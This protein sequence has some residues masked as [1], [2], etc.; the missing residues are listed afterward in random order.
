MNKTDIL[1]D[2][3]VD[4]SQL[5]K[6]HLKE[7][8][9]LDATDQKAFG[10]IFGMMK[11]AID[12]LSETNESVNESASVEA[13]SISKYT[14][15]RKD[16]VQTF[17]DTNN[18]NAKGLLSYVA[19]GKMKERMEFVSALAGNDGNK[20]QKNIIK[21]FSES[22]NEAKSKIA[23]L[24]NKLVGDRIQKSGLLPLLGDNNASL[25]KNKMNF[26]KDLNK[27]LLSLFKKYGTLPIK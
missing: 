6:K 19:K 18:L 13:L 20:S 12:D 25:N 10:K 4:L 23:F 9:K 5:V 8:K 21:M 7:I 27:S 24:N 1:Q 16:A 3:S 14:G 2:I 15:T 11:D 17:I 26:I 22:V